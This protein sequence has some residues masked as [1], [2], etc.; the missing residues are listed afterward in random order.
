ML[1]SIPTRSRP[2]SRNSATSA[3][4]GR[5]A[6][7]ASSTSYPSVRRTRSTSVPCAPSG[8]KR[9][10]PCSGARRVPTP[11]QSSRRP[12]LNRSAPSSPTTIG[13]TCC[14]DLRREV[15]GEEPSHFRGQLGVFR[16]AEEP[17]VG[18]GLEH[19]QLRLHARGAQ[20]A[21]QP[22]RVGEEEV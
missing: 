13:P 16:R 8:G 11:T 12:T 9:P 10:I 18:H 15:R 14:A 19:V 20:L 3:P 1:R 17:A 6:T 21:V 4:S 22:H 7:C 5:R 2:S